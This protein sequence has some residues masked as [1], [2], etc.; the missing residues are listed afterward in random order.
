MRRE[1]SIKRQQFILLAVTIS[2]LTAAILLL[3]HR[4]SIHNGLFRQISDHQ[5]VIYNVDNV[6]E[7]LF[8]LNQQLLW[9]QM[10]DHYG[11]SNIESLAGISSMGEFNR[12]VSIHVLRSHIGEVIR[13]QKETGS[14]GPL[15]LKLERQFNGLLALGDHADMRETG[16][17]DKLSRQI[18]GMVLSIEQLEG[19]HSLYVKDLTT[20]QAW[21]TR[22]DTIF[23]LLMVATLVLLSYLSIASVMSRV[24]SMIREQH[25]LTRELEYKNTELERFAYTVSHDLKSPLVTIKN[26]IGMLERN[27]RSN[28]R[29]QVFRD[30]EYISSAADDMAA[31]LEGLLELSRIGRIVNPSESGRL[32]DLVER[33]ASKLRAKIEE[34]GVELQ[35][36]ADM[37]YY[38][39]DSLRLREVFQNLIENAV[40]FMGNQETP[41][42][43]ISAHLK[44]GELICSVSDNGI[45]IDPQYKSRVFD[46]FERLDQSVEGTGIGLAL[47]QRIV[48]AHGGRVW[49]E[50][51]ANGPGCTVTLALPV[52]PDEAESPAP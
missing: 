18:E 27:V 21:V 52:Q 51:A 5:R 31:L 2:L 46:L 44:D 10:R 12:S 22:R 40:K 20:H 36:D 14:H 7:E 45:G 3:I 35:I 41:L 38:W 26:F 50:S 39:G 48:E 29:C 25:L 24:Q 37:P 43:G 4:E 15:S 30:L 23:L 49:I 9:Q 47:V 6:K 17:L 32:N 28:D 42:I 33:A 8:V 16:G 11:A 13:L 19:V 1:K 34:S